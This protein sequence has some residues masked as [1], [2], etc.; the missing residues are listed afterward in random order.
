MS[1]FFGG[2]KPYDFAVFIG[3]FQPLHFGHKAVIDRALELAHNVVVLVGSA[4]S[5]R[6]LR[7]PFTFDERKYMIDYTYRRE[8]GRVHVEP[9]PDIAYNDTSWVTQVQKIVDQVVLRVINSGSPNV[10]LSGTA[11]ARVCLIGHSK[12][13]TSYYLK[14]FPQWGAENVPQYELLASTDIRDLFFK[15]G[16]IANTSI[17]DTTYNF[18]ADFYK[19]PEYKALQEEY[20]FIANYKAKWAKSPY[21]PVF[22]TG[23]AVVVQSGHILLV[24]RGNHPGKGLLALPGGFVN[25]SEFIVDGVVRELKEETGIQD[26]RGPIPPGVLRGFIENTKVYDNPN[27]DP[28]GRIIT[29]AVLFK[30]PDSTKLYQVE[31]QDDAEAAHWVPLGTLIRADMFADHYDIIQDMLAEV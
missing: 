31:G 28:R 5:G 10:H 24:K 11:D 3:R 29:H 18:L 7:N 26:N 27:R 25:Q 15:D 2:D 19:K 4:D 30:L 1:K 14:L 6:T 12:D 9:L 8:P 16:M 17:P 21:P 13:N 22:V 20:E 23:D